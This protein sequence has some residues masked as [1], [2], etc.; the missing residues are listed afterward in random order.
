MGFVALLLV[1]V[2]GFQ[3]NAS[4][5]TTRV[6]VDT[7][8]GDPNGPS[9]GR[10]SI[11]G[12]RRYVAFV[13]GASDLVPGDSF[14]SDVF[15]R[16][17]QAGT[18]T[19]ATVDTTGSDP[20]NGS[21]D[22]SISSDGRYVAFGSAATDLVPSDGNSADD[23]FVRDLR[24]GTTTRVSVDLT[25]ADADGPSFEASISGDG[26][27]VAFASAASD[28]VPGDG[29]AAADVFVRDLQAGTTTRVSVD[30]T[31]GDPDGAS[32]DPSISGD[33]R[34]VALTSVASDLV[35]GDGNSASDVFVRDRQT[36][37]TTRVS[38]DATGGDPDGPSF[39]PEISG[40]GRHVAFTSF[41]QDL[42]PG[43]GNLFFE[44]LFVRDR[45]TNT[46]TRVS[47]DTADGDPDNRSL[48]PS[49]SGD[50][51]YVAFMSFASDLIPDD[52]NPA[53]DIFVRDRQTN[54]T[55]RVSVDADGG[56]AN[57]PSFGVSI[58]GDGRSIAFTSEASDLVPGDG[59]GFEDAF[60]RVVTPTAGKDQCKNGGWRN[61]TGNPGPFRNQGDCVSFF[62]RGGR[63]QLSGP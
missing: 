46:T 7:A 52:G 20:N 59:N 56:D 28:L 38:L 55:S 51:R 34:Y 4:A 39:D 32:D 54:T 10:P 35:P 1:A 45:Q 27:F 30:T 18:T 25:G 53:S 60:V 13:S 33:G 6:S 48:F 31:G 2:V 14:A 41:A 50:G 47:V 29:N 42:V 40:D 12:D 49:I 23:V 63:N 57:G 37:T 21:F 17:L 36:N 22:P 24:A 15:V 11:S 8:G 19:R 61:F 43:D 58:S 26:R 3:V 44:D 16:D 9:F 5:F 62:A